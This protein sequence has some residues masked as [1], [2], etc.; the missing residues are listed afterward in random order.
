MYLGVFAHIQQQEFK[1]LKI[2]YL[3]KEL[4]VCTVVEYAD[5]RISNFAIE[6]LCKN[7]NVRKTVFACSYGAQVESFKQKKW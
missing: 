2:T 5:M 4:C 7:E 6:Y 1:N 3:K